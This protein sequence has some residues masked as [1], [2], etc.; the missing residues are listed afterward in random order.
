MG[1]DINGKDIGRG[2]GQRKDNGLY[3]FEV[4]L[5]D[6]K[7][8]QIYG[9]DLQSLKHQKEMYELFKREK[10][11][12]AAVKQLAKRLDIKPIDKGWVYFISD[13]H[14][15]KI[16][17]TEN[18]ERRLMAI[19]NGNPNRISIIRK[20]FCEKP[21]YVEKM[22]HELFKSFRINGEWFDIMNCVEYFL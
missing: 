9:R 17:H 19:Q 13:G 12:K 4:V 15:I 11:E 22:Y 21:A 6:G 20:I 14:Y 16:G 3:Y 2:F 10:R 7:R 18:L 8:N 5:E 1:R